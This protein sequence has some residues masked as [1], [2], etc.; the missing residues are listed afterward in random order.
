MGK[1]TSIN[2]VTLEAMEAMKH[3]PNIGFYEDFVHWNYILSM[4]GL[5]AIPTNRKEVG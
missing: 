2:L 5:D 3:E 1:N 4:F